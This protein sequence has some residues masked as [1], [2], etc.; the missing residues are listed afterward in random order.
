M[1]YRKLS[2]KETLIQVNM[3]LRIQS[4][5]IEKQIQRCETQISTAASMAMLG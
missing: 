3:N 4:M 1:K 2:L 5:Q